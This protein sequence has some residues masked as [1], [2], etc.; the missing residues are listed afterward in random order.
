MSIEVPQPHPT[1]PE[2]APEAH[3]DAPAQR[4]L[5]VRRAPKFVPFIVLGGLN[6]LIVA[7][8]LTFTGEPNPDYSQQTVLGFVSVFCLP[9]GILLGALASLLFNW[10][11]L[12]RT[13]RVVVERVP[14]DQP[15]QFLP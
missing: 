15:E 4:T 8:I 7:G 9:P 13:K 6:G 5:T 11:S 2:Q 1:D 3:A 12:K 10:V 14:E